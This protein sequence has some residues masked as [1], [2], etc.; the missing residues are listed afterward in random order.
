MVEKTEMYKSVTR[1]RARAGLRKHYV[2]NL[3]TAG[4]I[5][6]NAALVCGTCFLIALGGGD[7]IRT[8]GTVTRTAV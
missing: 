6:I 3:L 8:R 1:R 7:E 5:N 2:R 4:T